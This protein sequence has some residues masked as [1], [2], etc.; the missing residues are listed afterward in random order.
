MSAAFREIYLSSH[1]GLRLYHRLYEG[2]SAG[3][4]K[5]LCLHGLTR[6]SRDFEDLA[7]HLQERYRVIVPDLRGRGLSARDPDMQNY[8]PT[9][10]VQDVLAMLAT[11]DA[12]PVTIIGTSLG[13]MLAMMLAVRQ[14]SSV[15]GIVLNDVGPEI[16]PAGIKRIKEY[17]GLL[18]PPRSWADA[19]VQ[20]Q[21]VYGAAWPDLAPER[22]PT[23]ARRGYREN[24]AGV[25]QSDYDPLIGETVRAQPAAAVDLWP[26]WKALGDLPALVIRGAHSDILSAATVARMRSEKPNVEQLSVP[27]RGHVPLLDEPECLSA[28]DTFL[29]RVNNLHG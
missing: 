11:Y 13:G 7:P 1:D 9:I 26:F 21:M 27:N 10:Y 20:A 15:A 8:Q 16:D 4:P 24:A 2:P 5:V 17:A 12:A 19:I 25:P 22:W 23:I 3:A 14:R 28:I 29:Q 18:P 6:N